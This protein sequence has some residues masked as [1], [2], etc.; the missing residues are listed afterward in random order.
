MRILMVAPSLSGSSYMIPYIYAKVLMRKHKVKIVGQ[1]FG[2]KLFI[3]DKSMDV[4]NLEPHIKRPVQVGMMNSIP[5]N[6]VRLMKNDFDVIHCFKLLPH[7]APV[8]SIAKKITKKPLVL[9]IDD[10]D[11]A[12]PENPIK[13][14]L[15]ELSERFYKSADV[16]TVPSN[17]LR[18]IYGGT[19]IHP[20]IDIDKQMPNKSSAARLRKKL[21]LQGKIVVT[22]IGTLY[23]T[24][25]IDVLIE[26]V[27]KTR[28]DDIKLVLFE[29]GKETEAYK[30]ISGPETIWV[31][32]K[33][34]E[35]SLDYTMMSDIYVIPTKDTRYTR[36][37]TPMK[38]FEAMSM[39]RAIIASDIADIPQFLDHGR[40]GVLTR[41][42]DVESL[43]N[44]ILRLADDKKLRAKLGSRARKLYRER[45]HYKKE[46]EKLLKIYD[47][48]EKR[49]KGGKTR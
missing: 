9:T 42:N 8:C 7:T 20:P 36:V 15:L 31:K 44:A 16:V 29:F 1:A 47:E 17:G 38:I 25:G 43:K 35:K 34:G 10:Y 4:E 3:E 48:L 18:K 13:R 21:G 37:Q 23:K 12:S 41:P 28:R 24:K 40:A 26:A 22:Y 39:G 45:Y 46:G 14:S 30:K 33:T 11:K 2:K 6:M 49:M 5:I 27:K 32:K 19:I